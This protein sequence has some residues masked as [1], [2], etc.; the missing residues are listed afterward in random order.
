MVLAPQLFATTH[1]AMGRMDGAARCV[2][3]TFRSTPRL[4]PAPARI[5]ITSH[6]PT[7]LIWVLAEAP[8]RMTLVAVLCRLL[9]R[10]M[11]DVT[12]ACCTVM[13]DTR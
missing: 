9:V 4:R 12:T 5:G 11:A 6:A 2:S 7:G 3:P 8:R 10:L 13:F 1:Q